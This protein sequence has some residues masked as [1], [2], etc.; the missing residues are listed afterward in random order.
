MSALFFLRQY[1]KE[2]KGYGFA[3]MH[4]IRRAN[5]KMHSKSSQRSYKKKYCFIFDYFIY[6]VYKNF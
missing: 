3:C 1:P 2:K 4:T 6:L 5:Y